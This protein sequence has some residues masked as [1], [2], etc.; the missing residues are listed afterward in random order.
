MSSVELKPNIRF[1]L[2]G[3]TYLI[4]K[5]LPNEIVEVQDEQFKSTLN[6]TQPELV[7][8]LCNGNLKFECKG[9]NLE[10]TS[11]S[12]LKTSFFIESIEESKYK[13]QAIFRL[14][15]IR[16]LLELNKKQLRSQVIARVNEVNSWSDNGKITTENLNGST[17]YQTISFNTVYRWI[18]L[19][20]DSNG[21]IRSLFPSYHKSGGKGET[22]LD[23]DVV[24]IIKECINAIYLNE[25]RVS[26]ITLWNCVVNQIVD[27]NKF[28]L[29]NLTIPSYETLTRRIK[30]IPE[31]DLIATRIGRRT[32]EKTMGMVRDGFNAYYPLERVEI[33]HTPLD[34]IVDDGYGNKIRPYLILAIDKC[35]RNV[36]GF[37]IGMGNNVG[38]PEVALCIKHIISD[39]SY[40]KEAYPSIKNKWEAFGIPKKIVMDNGLEFKNEAMIDAAYQLGFIIEYCPPKTP[41]WK[42]SIERF[43]ET[44]NTGLIHDLPG[45]TRSNPKELGDDENPPKLACLT[46][47][48]LIALV[49]KWIIDVYTQDYHTGVEGRPAVLWSKLT[50]SYPVS[51]P[52]NISDCAILLGKPNQRK[53]TNKGV[54]FNCLHYN[55]MDLNRLLMQ[56]SKDNHGFDEQFKIKYDPMDIGEVYVYD[57]IISKKWIKVECTNYEYA[58]GL[59]EWE[60][61]EMRG[62]ARREYGTIDVVSL[63]EAK[64]EIREMINNDRVYSKS[65]IARA[66]RINSENE[67]EKRRTENTKTSNVHSSEICIN[68]SNDDSISNL[69]YR[70]DSDKDSIIPESFTR[71]ITGPRK[72]KVINIKSAKDDDTSTAKRSNKKSNDKSDDLDSI[73]FEGYGF[74]SFGDNQNE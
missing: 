57:H 34:V 44:I 47:S 12:N 41:E 55:N 15:V 14:E 22:R 71:N 6:F 39:K 24:K 31:Y 25:Q 7:K 74:S 69:G 65:E 54:E 51:W 18:K 23:P 64:H 68:A 40:V 59:S 61:K 70:V 46:F 43:F 42:G 10:T 48:T 29:K 5:L 56:F 27:Y 9:K 67:I 26:I 4:L 62:Y 1:E 17:Y 36:L 3:K 2:L 8:H 28:S 16:P 72:N 73:S 33:D 30:E 19:F 32:A 21:D 37:S 63:A 11:E 20:R 45:T 58:K 38:W 53:I 66:R 52:T 13:S 50:E 60:H 35:T 49:Y